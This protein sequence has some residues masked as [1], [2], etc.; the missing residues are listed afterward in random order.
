[1][2]IVKSDIAV[3]P[4]HIEAL[5]ICYDSK[6]CCENNYYLVLHSFWYASVI[7]K[8]QPVLLLKLM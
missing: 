5:R 7:W 4:L 8:V 6:F 2:A 1:M 3:F